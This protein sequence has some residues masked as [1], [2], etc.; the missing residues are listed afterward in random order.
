MRGLL[1]LIWDASSLSSTCLQRMMQL[2]QM[3][4]PG[5]AISFLTSACDL[6]QKLQSVILVGRA[7]ADFRLAIL[8]WRFWPRARRRGSF[9]FVGQAGGAFDQ[10]GDFFARLDDFIDQAISL[11]FFR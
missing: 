11:G 8:D 4:T 6:P 2:S 7:T 5:P 9:F 1:F 3:Y 10:A